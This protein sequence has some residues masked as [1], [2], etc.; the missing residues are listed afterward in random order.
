MP[1]LNFDIGN[2]RNLTHIITQ[3]ANVRVIQQKGNP[4]TIPG[5]GNPGVVPLKTKEL[6]NTNTEVPR[7]KDV[8]RHF[9]RGSN[10][11]VVK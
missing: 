7:N 8:Y 3:T 10:W 2:H 5:N 1:R 9:S 4:F 11:V 6:L